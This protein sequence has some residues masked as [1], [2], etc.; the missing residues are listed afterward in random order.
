[1]PHHIQIRVIPVIRGSI[2]PADFANTADY[3]AYKKIYKPLSL[4]SGNKI[5]FIQ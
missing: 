4:V 3:S 5:S 2:M 1:M